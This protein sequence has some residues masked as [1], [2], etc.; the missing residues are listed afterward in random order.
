MLRCDRQQSPV[1]CEPYLGESARIRADRQP[2]DGPG[3]PGTSLIL[4]SEGSLLTD[5]EQLK[6]Q[7]MASKKLR[8]APGNQS[9]ETALVRPPGES[10]APQRVLGGYREG[11]NMW[12]PHGSLDTQVIM[13]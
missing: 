7:D 9:R 11:Y 1:V 4:V 6:H 12:S 13:R 3:G 5:L 10:R 8:Q 2:D